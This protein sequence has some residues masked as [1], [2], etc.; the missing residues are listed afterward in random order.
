MLRLARR[1]ACLLIASLWCFGGALQCQNTPSSVPIIAA[2]EECDWQAARKLLKAGAKLNVVDDSGDFPLEV[3]IREAAR[4]DEHPDFAEEVLSA[5]ADPKFTN[6]A[7]DTA[8]MSAAW[9]NDLS[10]AKLLLDGGVPVNAHG[11]DGE[12][13]LILASQTCLD[14]KMVQLLLDAGGDPNAKDNAGITSLISAAH[15]GNDIAAEKLLKAGAD[16]A[17][18]TNR[19]ETAEDQSCDRG[20]KGK[21][22]VCTLVREASKK[23]KESTK[24]PD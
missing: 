12:T 14:G 7:G 4:C 1:W 9:Y 18:K 20:E 2:M 19:G 23:N 24:K 22:H 11:N 16:P 17:L 8:L 3:A 5:G 13:A 21:Y 10:M 6:A 15:A